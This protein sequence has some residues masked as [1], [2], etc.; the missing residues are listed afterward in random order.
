MQLSF[1]LAPPPLRNVAKGRRRQTMQ[2]CTPYLV[3]GNV[4]GSPVPVLGKVLG[5]PVPVL[6]SVVDVDRLHYHVLLHVVH[7]DTKSKRY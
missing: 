3:L 2:Y 6:G 5:S 1:S 7:Y 4:L